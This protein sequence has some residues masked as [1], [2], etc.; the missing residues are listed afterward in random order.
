MT[1][2]MMVWTEVLI[3]AAVGF[4]LTWLIGKP[5][6]R[7]LRILKAGQEIRK[8]GPS[9]HSTKAGTPTMGGIMFILGV[10][11]AVFVLGWNYMLDGEFAHLYVYFLALCFGIIGFV[12]DYRKVRQHQNEG[13]TA[14]QKFLLQLLAAARAHH[15]V[16]AQGGVALAL[17]LTGTAQGHPLINGAIVP[18]FRGLAN[19]HPSTV[20]DEKAV[21]DGSRR[22][23]LDTGTPDAPLRLPPGHQKQPVF[24]QPVGPSVRAQCLITVV[25]PPHLKIRPGRRVSVPDGGN[26]LPHLSKNSHSLSSLQKQK[27]PRCP[28]TGQRR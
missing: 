25:Q 13:L 24:I 14:K 21:A 1:S 16:I 27:H 7:E 15:H 5:V 28:L 10:G 20:V 12:D 11:I 9:W 4:V 26:I 23:N 3:A 22:V 18:N 6:L 8:E 2:M 17:V 19:H